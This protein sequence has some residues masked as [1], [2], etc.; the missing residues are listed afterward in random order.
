M[1]STATAS[2]DSALRASSTNSGFTGNLIKGSVVT[3][4]SGSLLRL[5]RG[6]TDILQVTGVLGLHVPSTHY[7]ATLCPTLVG[8][9]VP[10]SCGPMQ[11]QCQVPASGATKVFESPLTVTTGGASVTGAL[12]VSGATSVR[13]DFVCMAGTT[14]GRECAC[15]WW[16]LGLG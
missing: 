12:S 5:Q 16:G 2:I 13:A 1:V 8:G 4:A 3:G 10:L 6:T 9:A 7:A 11:I 14:F 15:V